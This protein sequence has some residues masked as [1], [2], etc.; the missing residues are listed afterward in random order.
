MHPANKIAEQIASVVFMVATLPVGA[1]DICT[2]YAAV[3]H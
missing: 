3:S 1:A 2:G